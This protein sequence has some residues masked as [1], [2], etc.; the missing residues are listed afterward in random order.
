MKF[1]AQQ[2]AAVVQGQIVGNPQV[3][4]QSFAKIE[5]GQEGDICFLA[6]PKY[7]DYLYTTKASIIL[8]NEQVSLKQ[9][10]EATLIRVKDAYAAFALLLQTYQDIVGNGH[11]QG[12]EAG[13]H[14][15][16]KARVGE[17]C[18]VG[19]FAYIDDEAVLEDGVIIYPHVYI[20]KG[21]RVGKGSV[22]YSGVK[23]YKDCV[24]GEGVIIH[25]GTVV[26]SD[27]FG[28]ALENGQFKK[29]PQIGHVIIE[30]H[31][32]IGAN[33]TIDRA[34]MGATIIRKGA[35]LDNLIQVAHNVEIGEH[36]VVAAQAG[37]SGSTK[38]GKYVMIGGQAGIVGHIKIADQVRINAQSGVSKEVS[39]AGSALTGSPAFEYQASLRSQA[40]MRKLPEL[41]KRIEVLE[42]AL[43]EKQQPKTIN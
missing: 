9:D 18:Y 37:I 11:H 34:T 3:S 2:I 27:G 5:E 15:S 7:E 32:E 29:I 22:L 39:K 10:L 42:R 21:V 1:T 36:T 12:V 43:E 35:K 16:E 26:G 41:L 24:I 17:K 33:C 23:V 40:V 28:F 31:V 30:D 14:V 8:L 6:N 19:A 4:V 20:G 25:S 13:S 38:I